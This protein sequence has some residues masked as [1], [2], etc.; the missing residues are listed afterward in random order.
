MKSTEKLLGNKNMYKNMTLKQ[1]ERE[2]TRLE[3]L[4]KVADYRYSQG[5]T[6]DLKEIIDLE[7]LSLS[8]DKQELARMIKCEKIMFKSMEK[9]LEL[10]DSNVISILSEMIKEMILEGG[11]DT[12][13]F[14]ETFKNVLKILQT[15]QKEL[16]PAS[17]N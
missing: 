9:L 15:Q 17:T 11:M 8:N 13:V 4:K 1:V 14:D 3:K 12:T 6:T 7:K 10:D 16:T 5:Q 2:I